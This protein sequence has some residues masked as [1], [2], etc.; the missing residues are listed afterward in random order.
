MGDLWA[1]V[2]NLSLELE[3]ELV[4]PLPPRRQLLLRNGGCG[5]F[6]A[7]EPPTTVEQVLDCVFLAAFLRLRRRRR[8]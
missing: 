8:R 3:V 7:H 4:R 2:G 5:T 6:G 1:G